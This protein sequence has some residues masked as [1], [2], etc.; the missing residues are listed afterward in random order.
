MKAVRSVIVS[1]GSLPPNEI[2]RVVQ[3]DVHGDFG[4]IKKLYASVAVP[5]ASVLV[6]S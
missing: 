2:D 1:N 3:S 4:C 5:P 6:L